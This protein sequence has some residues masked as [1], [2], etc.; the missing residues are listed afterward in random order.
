MDPAKLEDERWRR[1]LLFERVGR[2]TVPLP[3]LH[4]AWDSATD[5]RPAP[6]E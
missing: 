2:L 6:S 4:A 5:A 1:G 3:S